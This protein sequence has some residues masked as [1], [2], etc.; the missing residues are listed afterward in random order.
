[1]E[2]LDLGGLM[3]RPLAVPLALCA[4]RKGSNFIWLREI[5]LGS[6]PCLYKYCESSSWTMNSFYLVARRTL[7]YFM[8][9]NSPK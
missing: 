5:W 8:Q 4:E 7:G 3:G 2:F 1:M 9:S 6:E